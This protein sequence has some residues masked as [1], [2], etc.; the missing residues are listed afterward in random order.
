MNDLHASSSH[1]GLAAGIFLVAALLARIYTGHHINKAGERRTMISGLILFLAVQI[2]YFFAVDIWVFAAIR[3]LHGFAFGIC[4]TA[5][6]T[7]AAKTVPE[8]RRSEG[9]G[10]FMLSIT[11]ASAAGP[12]AGLMIY[13]RFGFAVLTAFCIVSIACSLMIA[14]TIHL[15]GDCEKAKTLQHENR[16]LKSYFEVKALPIALISLVIYFCYS[17][18]ISFFSTYMK[19]IDLMDAGNY[20]FIVYSAAII[21]SRP[22][23]GKIAD[24]KGFVRVMYPSLLLFAAGM[25][26]LSMTADAA[27]LF[28]SAVL[29]GVG[30]GTFAAMAQVIAIQKVTAERISVAISTVLAISELGTGFGPYFIGVILLF[31]GYRTMYMLLAGVAAVCIAAYFLCSRRDLV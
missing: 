28:A 31:A 19:E 16:G 9:M 23:L 13:R 10:Y 11:F 14:L 20:F 5:I 8:S 6:T 3:F 18:V 27:I 4:T 21:V 12:F 26:L 1:A 25:V 22:W 30:F 7:L 2:T 24:A 15:P 29:L 17:G